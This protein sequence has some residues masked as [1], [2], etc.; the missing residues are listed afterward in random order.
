MHYYSFNIADYRKDTVHL[1]PVEHFIYRSLIDW[2]YLDEQPIPKKTQ[3]VMRRLGLGSDG[4]S[5]LQ[6]VLDDFFVE[7][8]FGY[9]HARIEQE[10]D[11]YRAKAEVSRVNGSKG[12]RP[13][14]PRK[15]QQVILANPEKPSR[16]LTNNHKPITNNHINTSRFTPPTVDEVAAYCSERNNNINAED[17]VDHYEANGWM[18]GKTKIKDWKACVRTWEKNKVGRKEE[19]LDVFGAGGF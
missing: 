19:Q 9:K 6:N 3:Q 15:T 4:L 5:S 7:S 18:R 11:A 17:F 14:K 16:N 12:G 1:T 10:I 2:Y 13:K 8:E